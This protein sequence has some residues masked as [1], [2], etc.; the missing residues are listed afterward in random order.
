ME[1]AYVEH[2][3]PGRVRVRIPSKR[4][5]HQFLQTVHKGLSDHPDVEELRTNP[6]TGGLVIHH[7]GEAEDILELAKS[8]GFF[9]VGVRPEKTPN[10]SPNERLAVEA[11][12]PE[13]RVLDTAIAG[14]AGLGLFQ[15]ARGEILGS[16]TENFWNAYSAHRFLGN[17]GLAA[18]FIA[19]G[20]Y[21]IL[22]GNWFG[23][24]AS[25]LFY[26][27]LTSHLA[28]LE[29]ELAETGVADETPSERDEA[30]PAD[31]GR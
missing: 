8:L 15:V 21:Q 18:A 19:F 12:L 26:S 11:E 25:L 29:S 20:L 27:L 13:P 7:T 31:G 24:A 14:L 23:S 4:G 1:T 5:D 30:A 17:Y 6:L 9:E 10:R 2:K 22:R 16:A 3:I 28:K